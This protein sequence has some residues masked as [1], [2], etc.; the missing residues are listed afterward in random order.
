MKPHIAFQLGHDSAC[1]I[2]N[3]KTDELIHVEFERIVQIKH[4]NLASKNDPKLF[5]KCF[6]VLFEK[7][8]GQYGIEPDFETCSVDIAVNIPYTERE[9]VYAT[10]KSHL[11]ANTFFR[12]PVK[13]H[14]GHLYCGYVQSPFEEAVVLSWDG[15]GMNEFT[16]LGEIK[17]GE[18]V[19]RE[20][21]RKAFGLMYNV[22]GRA[23]HSL[24]NTKDNL[25][26][27]GKLMGLA[28]YGKPRKSLKKDVEVLSEMCEIHG[29]FSRYYY[30]RMYDGLRHFDK[31]A[32]IDVK[33][34]WKMEELYA[35]SHNEEKHRWRKHFLKDAKEKDIAYAAQKMIEWALID[36]VDANIDRIRACGNNF[37]ISGG[38][39][40][41]VLAN[42]ALKEK[43]PE[44]NIFVPSN[45]GDNGLSVGFLGKRMLDEGLMSYKK[46]YDVTYKGLT[47]LDK[48][49]RRGRQVSVKEVADLLKDR[50]IIGL[51]QGPGENG[52]RA[53]GNRSIICSAG[54]GMKDML[55][56]KVKK[57]EHFRPFAPICKVED[58]S[59]WFIADHFRSMDNM[60]FVAKPRPGRMG[61]I[62]SAVHSGTSRLQ[63]VTRYNNPVLWDILDHYN[64]VL[65]NTSFNVAGKPILNT[66]KEAFRV[67]DTTKMDYV[68]Y[69]NKQ[70]TL[71]LFEDAIDENS[72]Q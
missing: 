1:T 13:H 31:G 36:I 18:L 61:T 8:R 6:R 46:S 64:G 55:N 50:K 40:L 62:E 22:V 11:K 19:H 56:S 3:P 71:Y 43:Y 60:T 21:I 70:G 53:L 9:S 24:R 52:P 25:D 27:A 30:S 58:A 42:T 28:P 47:I 33:R 63:T 44:L 23:C 34:P 4:L 45:G 65:L 20:D 35:A 48:P 15:I 39:S 5:Q 38:V 7:L 12:E 29:S 32:V 10:V 2:Y 67:L 51:I 59:T 69:V 72:K 54:H 41:N 17:Q 16:V 66:F 68:L 37:I 57:R 14:D 49:D 26:I